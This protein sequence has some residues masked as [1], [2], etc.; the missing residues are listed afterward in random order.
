MKRLIPFPN[1]S[2]NQLSLFY[3]LFCSFIAIILL[4]VS[5]HLVTYSFF[6]D[7]I[8]EEIIVNSGL[9]LNTT[10]TNYEKHFKLM[11]SFML[12]TLFENDTQIL[13]NGTSAFHYDIVSR[14]Q[15]EL[16]NTMNNSL[17]Y[18]DN[19]IYY[20]KDTG[21]VFDKEG[22]RNAETMFG[23][24]YVS[25]TYS[26]E[27]WKRQAESV[28]SFKVYPT[29]NFRMETAFED[30]SYGNLT[31]IL[32]KSA[33]DDRL[34]FILL[35]KSARAFE[36][37][38]QPKPGSSLLILDEDQQVIYSSSPSLSMPD[39]LKMEDG[40]YPGL[41][42]Y[43]K[44]DDKYYFFRSGSETGFTY[45]EVVADRGLTNQL[46][47]LN[48]LMFVILA[49]SILISLAVS[50]ILAKKF[51][52]PLAKMIRSIQTYSVLGGPGAASSRIKEF[53]MLH[54]TLRDLSRSNEKFHHD[55][56]TKNTMLQQFAYMS[57]LKKIG[58]GAGLETRMDEDRPYRLVLF[59]LEFKERFL[60][61]ISSSVHRAFNTYKELIDAHFTSLYG[62]SLTFQLEKDQ[63]L[64]ILFLDDDQADK[65]EAEL[66]T[67]IRIFDSDA[68][69]CNF[70]IAPSP[71]RKYATDFAETYQNALDL[72]RQRKLGEDVQIITQWE[73][74]PSLLVPTPSEET[75]LAANLQA[76]IETVTIPLVERFLD[77][78]DKA[79]ATAG[80]F[81]EWSKDI[82]NRTIKAMYAQ[83][84][85]VAS[86]V[87]GSHLHE[88]L[89]SCY[90]L[91]QYK[92]FF[93][94]LLTRSAIAIQEK[95]SET[96]AITKFVF[97]YVEA[98]YG[99]DLS[100]DAIAHKLG[101]TGP[102][103]SSYFKEKTGT[104]FSDYIYTVRMNKAT[105]MLIETDLL[106]QDI[107]SL[108]GYFTVASF[109]RV[110]KRYTG[111][112]PSEFR[113]QNIKWEE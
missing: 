64:T 36:A 62:E 80:Q 13:K 92:T 46:R 82:V 6:R 85:S 8:K 29:T 93:R 102:Y 83:N 88:Q 28:D 60:L 54:S 44:L 99:G 90:T 89:K 74:H 96:D 48:V 1:I 24:F 78:L 71:V 103:L 47:N 61:E 34:A 56:Q 10:V 42:G 25:D 2:N 113:R 84:V 107:A 21:F 30:F 66:R 22:T 72:I 16:R 100:L 37:F 106:I 59:H 94:R 40:T 23:K 53:N 17:L 63:I 105:E 58:G 35:L 5:I 68:P 57:K 43:A 101:I 104:N 97:E 32:V 91:E 110:F 14:V 95:K 50:Y 73:A 11:R 77:H 19:I 112:T 41:G 15:R 38:H 98:N 45:V 109:N 27:F 70:T 69:Y 86:V 49:L 79:G 33:Y 26:V 9:N 65:P 12:S 76:G 108:V 18:L 55:L 81:Q 20:F 87:D 3:T 52:N 4:L 7:R 111:M 51:H 67:L 31:P 39:N 75:E